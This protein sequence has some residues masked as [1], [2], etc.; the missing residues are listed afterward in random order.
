VREAV[1]QLG[2]EIRAGLHTGE[3]EIFGSTIAG[4]A[5]HTGARVAALAG[6]GE[7]LLTSTVR[8]LVAGSGLELDDRGPHELKGV[9]GPWRIFAARCGVSH[10]DPQGDETSS[11]AAIAAP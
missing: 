5:V 1:Q 2:L 10:P 8:D 7:I 9:P 4:L 6:P 11:R 3:C